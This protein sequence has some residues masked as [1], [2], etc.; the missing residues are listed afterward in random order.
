VDKRIIVNMGEGTVE[1]APMVIASV[2]LGSCVVLMLYDPGAR[3]GGLAHILLPGSPVRPAGEN[4]Q[5]DRHNPSPNQTAYLYA[6]TALAVLFKKMTGMGATSSNIYAMIAGGARMFSDSE[7]SMNGMGARN[8]MSIKE[9][10]KKEKI[11]L[12]GEDTGGSHG[13]SVNFHLDSGR[14]IVSTIGGTVREIMG[15]S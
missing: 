8:I 6:D 3:I 1:R 11:C 15:N 14:V 5:R 4:G 13:R 2:G 9:L 12:I 10:L 7:P